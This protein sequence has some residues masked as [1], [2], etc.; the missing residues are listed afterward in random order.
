[1]PQCTTLLLPT[2]GF[3][4]SITHTHA[5]R[6]TTE[7]K[8]REDRVTLARQGALKELKDGA[9]SEELGV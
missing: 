6:M 3:S 8:T 9:L 7:I 1:M 4:Q 5:Q 2:R